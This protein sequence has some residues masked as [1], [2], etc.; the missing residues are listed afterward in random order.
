MKHIMKS[1]LRRAAALVGYEINRKGPDIYSQDGLRTVHSLEFSRQA[2]F[3]DAFNHALLATDNHPQHHG[4]WRVHVALWAAQNALRL[5]GDFVECGVFRGFISSAVM[6]YIDW[7]ATCGERRYFLFDTFSG[8]NPQLL[9][10]EESFRIQQYGDTYKD[11][12]QRV[13]EGF[14][15][16][17]NVQI[18]KGTVPESLQGRDINAVSF[19]HL[20]MN[21]ALPEVE[22]L[23][24]F[25]PKLTAGALVLMDD[26]A[27][28][29]YEPQHQALDEV[30]QSL[31]Y[32]ILSLPTG[33]GLLIK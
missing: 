1:M 23:Q 27:Y 2:R 21:S 22:A 12:Y 3:T 17:K 24:F 29:G 8:F 25:W 28:I 6:R 19:L 13:V 31:G 11:T 30:A 33:Q 20:D 7:N 10:P 4:P 32:E 14:S 16:F 18:I 15:D 26:Y 5:G 9:L